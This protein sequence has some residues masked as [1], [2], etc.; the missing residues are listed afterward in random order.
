MHR[1]VLTFTVLSTMALAAE[2]GRVELRDPAGDDH[3][4]GR[5]TYPTDAAYLKGSFDLL[6]LRVR[7]EGDDVVFE[8]EVA[9]KL[10]DPW[11][12]GVGFSLQHAVVFLDVDGDARNGQRDGLPGQ[13]VAFAEGHGWDRA[14][15]ITPHTP[16][17]V[18][19]ELESKASA[20]GTSV[21]VPAR[22]KGSGRVIRATVPRAQLASSD[23][24]RWRY[25]VTLASQDGFPSGNSVLL[26]QVNEAGGA[27]RFGG[28]D[29][30]QCDPQVL[31]VLAGLAV[32]ASGEVKAQ[33][34]QLAFE[35]DEAGEPRRRA[36]L[37]LIALP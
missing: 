33:A 15:L 7:A 4:P 24:R 36:T 6:A 30:G 5:Y 20:L 1:A 14:V 26:R 17:R 25:Q 34:E 29:D 10:E 11:R 35:C 37:R 12:L 32:G 21:V 8:L 31:D 18:Q 27:H 28:G 16:A 9:A 22:V 3:G 2:P 13:N 23:P 19:K